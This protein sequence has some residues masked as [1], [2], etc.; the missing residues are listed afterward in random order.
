MAIVQAA[1]YGLLQIAAPAGESWSLPR[2]LLLQ[3]LAILLL[4]IL[5]LILLVAQG[6]LRG[7]VTLKFALPF[8]EKMN[9]VCFR[10]YAPLQFLAEGGGWKLRCPICGDHYA[11]HDDGRA[12][13]VEEAI[14]RAKQQSST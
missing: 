12:I 13:P 2:R 6:Y 10:D 5:W 1:A 4:L 9:A 3:L 8:D 14:R 11:P 7:K